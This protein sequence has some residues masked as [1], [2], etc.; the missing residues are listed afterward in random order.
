MVTAA[1][2]PVSRSPSALRIGVAAPS[3]I[4]GSRRS[5]SIRCSAR[6]KRASSV[7]NSALPRALRTNW[8]ASCTSCRPCAMAGG[9]SVKP[10]PTSKARPAK[11][12]IAMA[13]G[14]VTPRR[15]S[16]RTG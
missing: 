14:R 12:T 1:A 10:N 15:S 5:A 2:M 16:M 11:V 7:P 4:S 3:S 6:W 13:Y 9:M 8:G